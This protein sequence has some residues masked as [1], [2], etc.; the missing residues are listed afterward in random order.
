MEKEFLLIFVSLSKSKTTILRKNFTYP[1]T[2]DSLKFAYGYLRLFVI[3]G[4]RSIT[5]LKPIYDFAVSW[6]S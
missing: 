6:Y 4:D 3:V 5:H 1:K 2:L